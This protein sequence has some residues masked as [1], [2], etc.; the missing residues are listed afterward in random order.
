MNNRNSQSARNKTHANFITTFKQ[1]ILMKI[2]QNALVAVLMF[3]FLNP[4]SA[5]KTSTDKKLEKEIAE[6]AKDFRGTV[7]VY[8]Y[9]LKTGKVA[10]LNAD[11]IF[12][13]ASVVKVPILVG[14]FDKIESG[15]LSYNKP[16]VYTR[17]LDYGGSGLMTNF[18]DSTK[19]DLSIAAALMITYSDNATSL[20]NQKMAGGGEAINKLMAKYGLDNTRVNSRT[21]GR[22]GNWREYGWGQTTPREMASLVVK[23][24]K[25]EVISEEASDR[26]Y[27]MLTNQYYEDNALSQIPPYVQTAC[28]TGAV[29]RSRSEVVM[30]NAPHG[31]YVFY[32]AT[33][34]NKDASWGKANEAAVL[35][36]KISSYLWNYF[37]PKSGWKP[38]SG[39]KF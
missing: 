11:T 27:R 34:N 22:D 21:E 31:D 20:W 36:R 24:R 18:K 14:L 10:T 23:I 15:E 16:L 33:K 17:D 32:I 13:T 12:P 5:Q 26:M 28:K 30:V 19:T 25:G 2:H 39:N 37:E 38:N 9:N 35:T 1:I 8:V 4:T 3:C 7:G 6:M 29:D